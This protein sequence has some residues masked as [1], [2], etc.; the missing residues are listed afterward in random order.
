MQC[1]QEQ[2]GLVNADVIRIQRQVSQIAASSV[3]SSVTLTSCLREVGS[4]AADIQQRIQ[5]FLVDFDLQYFMAVKEG[6]RQGATYRHRQHIN[7][8]L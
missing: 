2:L 8:T 1:L 3:Q 5:L 4:I 7:D 6:R